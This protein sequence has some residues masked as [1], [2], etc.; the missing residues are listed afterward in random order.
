MGARYS[1][2]I[3]TRSGTVIAG[4]TVSLTDTLGALATLYSDKDLT[5]PVTPDEKR[6]VTDDNG[7]VE[8]WVAD[9]V[10]T[11][12]ETFEEV[13]VTESHWQLFDV[14]ALSDAVDDVVNDITALTSNLTPPAQLFTALAGLQ[15]AAD[16]ALVRTSG[17]TVFGRGEGSYIEVLSGGAA[18]LAAHPN[19]VTTS[20]GGS[21]YWRLLPDADGAIAAEQGGAVGDNTANDQPAWQ[22]AILYKDAMGY[23]NVRGHSKTYALWCPIRTL[24]VITFPFDG[25]GAYL[26]TRQNHR[27][28]PGAQGWYKFTCLNSTGGTNDTVTQTVDGNPWRGAGFY[29]WPQT[30]IDFIDMGGVEFDGTR[31][32]TAGV[33]TVDLTHKGFRAQDA[34]VSK[35]FADGLIMRNFAGE[36]FYNGALPGCHDQLYNCLFENSPQCAFNPTGAHSG[37]YVNVRAGNSSLAAEVVGGTGRKFINCEFFNG[38]SN[39]TFLGGA[40][41]DGAFH[42]GYSYSYPWRTA[43]VAPPYVEFYDCIFDRIA[44]ININGC[45]FKGRYTA[46]DSPSAITNNGKQTDIDL[47]IDYVVDGLT[48]AFAANLNSQTPTLTT[49]VPSAPGGV[50]YETSRNVDIR[51]NVRRT[52]SAIAGGFKVQRIVR[53]TRNLYDATTCTIAISGE[54]DAAFDSSGSYPAS[55]FVWPRVIVDWNN[56]NITGSDPNEA[57]VSGAFN[58]AMVPGANWVQP[59]AAGTHV[60]TLTNPYPFVEGQINRIIHNGGAAQT[61][62]H[63]SLAK[64]GAGALLSQD[65]V[66]YQRADYLELRWANSDTAFVETNYVTQ[67]PLQFKGSATYDAPSIAAGGTTTTTVTATGAALGD[68]VTS[69]SFGVSLAGLVASGYVSSANTVTVVLYNPTAGAVDLASTTLRVVVDKA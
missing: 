11:V 16:V 1:N 62:R 44:Q 14:E 46:I 13:V 55:G 5:T 47:E 33:T 8:F 24:S 68:Q 69:I 64:S 57:F 53:L 61:D 41:G 25:Q 30:S 26:Y 21:R 36:I 9:G 22:S 27:F 4:A 3:T 23:A 35:V 45:F 51:V 28:L 20:N 50:F 7:F 58:L 59:T 39:C 43:G 65:R 60:M 38:T 67:Q 29:V 19:F 32:Y 18:L 42:S 10:Y 17:H 37:V 66:E 48:T 34:T 12:T 49:Q 52:A 15:I 56:L 31:T 40:A 63:F 2:T 6:A 54:G